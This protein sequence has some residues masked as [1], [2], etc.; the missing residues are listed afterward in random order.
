MNRK[1]T[2]KVKNGKVQK[3][4]RHKKTLNYWNTRQDILQIDRESPGGGFKHFLEKRYYRFFGNSTKPGI[5]QYQIRCNQFF[6]HK[7]MTGQMT[8]TTMV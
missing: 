6:L 1:T 8:G 5:N 7:E 3:K 4:N 2:P